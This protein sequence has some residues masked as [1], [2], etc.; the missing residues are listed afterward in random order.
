MMYKLGENNMTIH[1]LLQK[2][3]EAR[4]FLDG[5]KDDMANDGNQAGIRHITTLDMSLL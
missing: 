4:S 2:L 5:S 1:D 3:E